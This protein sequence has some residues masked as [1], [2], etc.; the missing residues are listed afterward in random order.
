[1]LA[2]GD[3]GQIAH[4]VREQ[5]LAPVGVV[6]YVDRDEVDALF[7]KKLFRSEAAASPGLGEERE[8]FGGFHL[9]SFVKWLGVRIEE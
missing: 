3:H 2:F 8:A 9:L 5:P 6:Q 7:R 4:S 1:L